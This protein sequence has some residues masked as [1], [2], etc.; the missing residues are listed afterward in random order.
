M[1]LV[2]VQS[3]LAACSNN[4]YFGRLYFY[5]GDKCK[6]IN[7]GFAR[8]DGDAFK[9]YNSWGQELP[10][11]IELGRALVDLK[12]CGVPFAWRR[13]WQPPPVFL[14]GESHRT[15]EPVRLQSVWLQK[16]R[17]NWATKHS[18]AWSTFWKW[19]RGVSVMVADWIWLLKC[20]ILKWLSLF[21]FPFLLVG[22]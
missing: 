13:A 16:V 11:L 8:V 12:V 1:T 9:P 2:L 4:I 17:H 6:H 18:T 3:Q 14:P 22:G 19:Y 15:K 21:F 10:N 5:F 20:L 7:F